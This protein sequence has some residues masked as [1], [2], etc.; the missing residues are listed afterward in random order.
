MFCFAQWFVTNVAR[1]W[2]N[3]VASV[4]GQFRGGMT[5]ND[6][7][8]DTEH[9][10]V[11]GPGAAGHDGSGHPRARHRSAF[12]RFCLISWWYFRDTVSW[13]ALHPWLRRGL[14]ALAVLAVASVVTLAAL[15]WRLSRGPIDFDLATAWLKSAIE[16]NFGA[17][18]T[19]AIGGTQL[20][21]DERGR[22]SVR[23]LDIAVR[24]QAGELV[25][26]APKAE[27]GIS[28]S[29]LLAGQ[30]RAASLNLVGAELSVRIERDG[31]VTVFAGTNSKPLART[32][33]APT[34]AQPSASA[35][36]DNTAPLVQH[37]I[38]SQ[39]A[40]AL[41]WIDKVGVTGLD[42]YEL[43]Q[44]GLKN[45]ILSVD[46][47]RTGKHWSFTDIHAD[48]S[49]PAQGGLIV[50][51]ASEAAKS[52]WD[53]RAAIRPLDGDVRA[54]GIEARNVSA[55]DLL[56]AT[57]VKGIEADF[58]I[59]TSL[60]AEFKPDGSLIAARG[61]LAIG[62]GSVRDPDNEGSD[63]AIQRAELHAIW[64]AEQGALVMPFHVQADGTQLTLL[65]QAIPDKAANGL[66]RLTVARGDNVVDPIIL[67]GVGAG[68]NANE[69]FA[70]NR[71]A[72]AATVDMT[73]RLVTVDRGDFGRDDVR[74]SHN[75]G[76]A[77][78]G[79][80]DYSVDEP[81]L[82]FGVAA[83]RMPVTVFK[84]LWPKPIAPLV[85]T[86]VESHVFAGIIERVVI[87]GNASLPVLMQPGVPLPDEGLSIEVDSS[88]VAMRPVPTLPEIRD[89]DLTVRVTGRT[90]LVG[91]GRGTIEVGDGRR[92]NIADGK[93]SVPDTHPKGA[94]A[95]ATFR[96]DGSVPAAAALIASAKF[97]H[98]KGI[99]LDPATSRGTISAQVQLNLK[100]ERDADDSS[101]QYAV[102]IDMNN[103]VADRVL[104][105]QKLEANALRVTADTQGFAIK[106]D[107]KIGG[108]PA[109]LDYRKAAAEPEA[110]LRLQATLD[111][112]ARRRL[113]ADFGSRLSGPV[114]VKVAGHIRPDDNRMNLAVETDFTA[115]KVTDLLPGWV[116]LAG[117]QGKATFTLIRD[118]KTTRLDDL[119][120]D[121]QGVVVRG[122]L[123]LDND[124]DLTTASFPV[125]A[126]S[127]GD[128]ATL[129]LERNGDNVLRVILRGDVFDGRNFVKSEVSDNSGD[130]N[131]ETRDIDLDVKLGAVAGFNGEALRG[132][133]LRLNKRGGNVRSFSLNAKI[134]RDAALTGDLRVRPRE[135]HQVIY[136][137]TGDAGALF[138]FTD[139][140]PRM[141]GGQLWT[142]FDPPNANKAP[143]VGV[144]SVRNFVVRGEQG[145]QRVVGAAGDT[146][147]RGIDFTELQ[148]D[149]TRQPGRMTI[150]N[151]VVRGPLVGATIDGQIDYAAN[152]M[153]LRGTFVPL[154]AINNVF[155]Q[156]PIVGLFLGGGN[157]EGL[158]GINYETSGPPG[159]PRILFNPISAVAPGLFRK[160]IPGP[161]TFDPNYVQPTP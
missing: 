148:A 59:T 120:V 71:V 124:G 38:G 127:D 150:R 60:R 100:L 12:N 160:F 79:S 97:Q 70:F 15:W 91:L 57:R 67:S 49:R 93:F 110:E 77:V 40:A 104:V 136:L 149:F 126:M 5:G 35:P 18:Y 82:N 129:R 26:S 92:L 55:R 24:D 102:A 142:A 62:H 147:Q 20:E 23:I 54:I 17:N 50:S 128:K 153:R 65:A 121:A 116:K 61:D 118:G 84:R 151:G 143:Q 115:A 6:D 101:A 76:V 33:L 27:I 94:P 114:A 25:A 74:A 14:I 1:V 103:L 78:T 64:N 111:E 108:T 157:K 119:A 96:V 117:R 32:P 10:H 155:G 9:G 69:S 113:G 99:N 72:I 123:E 95:T 86:W 88:A 130:T 106:G 52:P 132:F 140:Y 34:T 133:D 146:S 141:F 109:A 122:A 159:A 56:L 80:Y 66:W 152:D 46:D 39:I 98:A 31:D 85:R 42:G 4:A 7:T 87:A 112:A 48:V 90:A 89:A 22:P 145:L 21:R 37:E 47:E 16:E 107:V 58:P 75:V 51:L 3:R 125:F 19:V 156:I 30:L 158:V 63:F 11:T 45:G 28:A 144:L 73:R 154:Y 41:A 81:R 83:T 44:L 161:G 2:R 105:G 13:L 135:T 138:R 139:T 137:E 29:G 134:G 8:S 68:T 53:I 36:A 131:K 43:R